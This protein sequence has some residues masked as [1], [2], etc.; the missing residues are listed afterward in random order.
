VSGDYTSPAELPTAL[1]YSAPPSWETH[2]SCATEVV[3]RSYG[4]GLGLSSKAKPTH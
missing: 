1:K 2:L 4:R 3:L